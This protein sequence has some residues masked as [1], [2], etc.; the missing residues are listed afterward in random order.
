M[1]K[2]FTILTAILA[3]VGIDATALTFTAKVPADTKACYIAGDFT[4]W[5]H[6]AMTKVDDVTFTIDFPEATETQWYKYCSGPGWEY[7]ETTESG[8]SGANRHY[9]SED[10]IPNW[11]S[12]YDPDYITIKVCIKYD[13]QPTIWWWGAGDK[14]PDAADT[15]NTYTGEG[16][17]TWPGPS[18][19]PM[20]DLDGWYYYEIKNVYCYNGVTIMIDGNNIS[21]D[22]YNVKTNTAF[23]VDG[24]YSETQW[25]ADPIYSKVK[26]C[27][28]YDSAPT[29]WWWGA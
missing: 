3:I 11:R 21:N 25:P 18:M 19:Q 14:C 12:I 15:P 29:I 10:I 24:S 17:Y 1:E 13:Y 20:T 9:S 27:I 5:S 8:E 7:E 23:T 22:G 6:A 16:N 28:Q 4:G 26:V 2:V